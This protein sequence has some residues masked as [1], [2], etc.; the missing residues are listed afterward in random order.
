MCKALKNAHVLFETG[1]IVIYSSL[2]RVLQTN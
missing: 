2:K 1:D